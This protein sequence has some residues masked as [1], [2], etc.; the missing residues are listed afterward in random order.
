MSSLWSDRAGA[1]VLVCTGRWPPPHSPCPADSSVT[2]P[3]NL[4]AF[5]FLP[6][7]LTCGGVCLAAC[8]FG[9]Q[10]GPTEL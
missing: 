4:S 7:Q 6:D 8:S 3:A 1:L 5:T 10:R 2:G 9:G